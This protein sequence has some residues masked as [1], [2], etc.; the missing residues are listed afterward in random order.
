MKRH[1]KMKNYTILKNQTYKKYK[2]IKPVYCPY[3]KQQVVFTGRGFW[4]MIYTGRNRKR[5]TRSQV[6]RFQ[7][8]PFAV[9][10]LSVTSTLQEIEANSKRRVTYYGFIA[11]ID[12]WKIKVIVKKNGTGHPFFWSVIPNWVTNKKRDKRLFKGDM[13]KD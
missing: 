9:K 12:N 3:L 13:E 4:H 6:L 7:L 2:H 8:L 1:I 10:I 11:I 5:E